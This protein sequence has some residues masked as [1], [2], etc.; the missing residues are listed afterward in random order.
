MTPQPLPSTT[1]DLSCT[2]SLPDMLLR[3]AKYNPRAAAVIM[4][5]G[6][7]SMSELVDHAGRIAA[8]ILANNPD[9]C[10]CLGIYAD[11]SVEMISGVWGVIWSGKAYVPLAVEYPEE[12]LRYIIEKSGIHTIL[13]QAHLKNQLENIVSPDMTILVIEELLTKRPI[14]PE[15]TTP[16][17]LSYV[18]YTSGS[19]GR[20]KGVMIEQ[21]AIVNQLSWLQHEGYL[22]PG[23][24]ILQKTPISFDAAQW[25]LL[26]PAVGATVVAGSPGLFKDLNALISNIQRHQVTI[27]QCV[28]TLL[29]ALIDEEPFRACDSLRSIYSGGEA[30][31]QKLAL[32]ILSEIPNI[33]LINLYGPTECTINATAHEVRATELTEP[34]QAVPIGR[35]VA[36]VFCFLLDADMHAVPDGQEGELYLGGVQLSRGYRNSPELTAERF[37]DAP[38]LGRLYRTGD[39]C[40]RRDDGKL[41]FTGRADNQVKLR[42]YRVELEEINIAIET[43]H[44]VRHASVVVVEDQRT[45]GQSLTACIQLN[46]KQAA[47][48]DQGVKGDH[49]QSKANKLQVKAQLSNPGLRDETG[50]T[51]NQVVELPGAKPT[52]DQRRCVFARKT[53]RFYD[54]GFV[55]HTDLQALCQ[56]WCRQMRGINEIRLPHRIDKG[57]LGNILRWF[58]CFSSDSRLLPK[59]AY[60]SPG[61]LYAT[62]LYIECRGIEGIDN[63]IYYYHPVNHTLIFISNISTLASDANNLALRFHFAGKR[64]AIEPIYKNNIQEVLEIETGHMLGLLDNV[65]QNFGL[66]IKPVKLQKEMLSVLGMHVDDFA[67]GSF[68][69]VPIHSGWRPQVELF[70]QTTGSDIEELAEGTWI[71]S[72]EAYSFKKISSK[73]IATHDVIA[74]N[75]QVYTRSSVGLSVVSREV[76]PILAYVSLGYALDKFQRNTQGFGFMSAGYSSKTGNPLAASCRLDRVLRDAGIVPGPTYF[77]VGGKVSKEQIIHEGMHEDSVHMQGPAE[78]VREEL[79]RSLPAY[80]IPDR[81]LVFDKLPITVN[82]KVDHKAVAASEQLREATAARPY[83]APKSTTETWLAELWAEMLSF[84]PV[85]REDEFFLSGGN[86][87]VALSMLCRINKRYGL[88]LPAQV[89]FEAPRLCDLASRIDQGCGATYSRFIAMNARNEGHPVFCWPG[90]GGYPMNLRALGQSLKRP[91]FG[92]QSY[93]L[94]EGEV[95]HAT[96]TDM[97]RADVSMIQRLQKSGPLTLWGYSFGARL[98]F[99]AAWQLEQLGHQVNQ[100]VLICPGNPHVGV[101]MG[102]IC[103]ETDLRNKSFTA[104]LLSVF[105]GKL[106]LNQAEECMANCTTQEDFIHFVHS[107]RPEI[108]LK[109]IR[110]ITQVVFKTYEFEYT[111][112]ELRSRRVRCPITIIKA[113]GD[114]YSF[115]ESAESYSDKA[116]RILHTA[117][118][119]Y[120][121]LQKQ[122]VHELASMIERTTSQILDRHVTTDPQLGKFSENN[123]ATH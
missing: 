64:A 63:G 40:L 11:P 94:N 20:P 18:I 119:H 65:I 120:S 104:V 6:C 80:M 75:Q 15:P 121:I 74:I 53:Y 25:E 24:R 87:L 76:D 56:D 5:S 110:R 39:I 14:E 89:I 114:D 2:S 111:F 73:S 77:F 79:S 7:L 112:S 48:M 82:G 46:E 36:G 118:D 88:D 12:R 85:S 123:H 67:I 8:G 116:P 58:G 66:G 109:T 23:E 1:K 4:D 122:S 103:R 54:G 117:R 71:V 49:H 97:A 107:R 115:L 55:T 90:L 9:A 41:H 108:D 43:H 86:S 35:P 45:K 10:D 34:S 17:S 38:T 98:A 44:W 68:E 93:G 16:S 70:V 57:L 37:V 32:R 31:S 113:R 22:Q 30:L 81:V 62:Q 105:M 95:P 83:I 69:S 13:T 50:N 92:I 78:M 33:R 3:Q 28:P 84:S 29:S 47:L 60:A 100:L 91:F 96:I 26:A 101:E 27:L 102:N 72:P 106:D 19:T 21:Q 99:E 61:A 51:S 42:G 52:D 59:Y